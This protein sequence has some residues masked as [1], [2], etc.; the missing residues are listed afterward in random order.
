MFKMFPLT[1]ALRRPEITLKHPARWR[2]QVQLK[3]N[4]LGAVVLMA[5]LIQGSSEFVTE[6]ALSHSSSHQQGTRGH[7]PS[8]HW[9]WTPGGRQ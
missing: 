8:A 9:K 1:F 7:V 3:F 2:A 5:K 6:V 4:D